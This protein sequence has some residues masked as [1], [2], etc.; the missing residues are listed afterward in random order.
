MFSSYTGDLLH[1]LRNAHKVIVPWMEEHCKVTLQ[2]RLGVVFISV[3]PQPSIYGLRRE[4]ARSAQTNNRIALH[5][6]AAIK[7]DVRKTAR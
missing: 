6:V 3:G 7:L 5:V 1:I 4:Q 2:S